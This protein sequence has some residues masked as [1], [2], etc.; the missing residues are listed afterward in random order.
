VAKG[1]ARKPLPPNSLTFGALERLWVMDTSS[2]ARASSTTPDKT[3]TISSSCLRIRVESGATANANA[4]RRNHPVTADPLAP[5]AACPQLGH[6]RPDY[7]APGSN[8]GTTRDVSMG[9]DTT[10]ARVG[11]CCAVLSTALHHRVHQK[12][13]RRSPAASAPPGMERPAIR[14]VCRRGWWLSLSCFPLGNRASG[15]QA[16]APCRL[17]LAPSSH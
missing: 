12:S 7:L 2:A 5:G 16:D 10:L 13:L 8:A 3:R 15:R 4:R 1:Q 11:G 6:C 14:R 17:L 9:L